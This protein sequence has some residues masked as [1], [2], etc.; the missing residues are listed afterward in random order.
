MGQILSC[1]DNLF[2]PVWITA[3]EKLQDQVPAKRGNDAFEW[4]TKPWVEKKNSIVSLL[5][6]IPNLWQRRGTYVRMRFWLVLHTV[7]TNIHTH[8]I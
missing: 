8:T 4:P 2:P 7:H 3:M 6:L 5:T 1:R